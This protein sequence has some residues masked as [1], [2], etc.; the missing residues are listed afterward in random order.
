MNDANKDT[1]SLNT[2]FAKASPKP[3]LVVT[4]ESIM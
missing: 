1:P 3:F 4:S 2:D